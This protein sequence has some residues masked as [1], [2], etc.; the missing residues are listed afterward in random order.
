MGT[1]TR[2]SG[3]R[4]SEQSQKLGV[5]FSHLYSSLFIFRKTLLMSRPKFSVE[6]KKIRE[7]HVQI[8][9]LRLSWRYWRSRIILL[10][11]S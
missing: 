1:V 6:H 7:L 3:R 9:G 2:L 11:I 5:D 4:H 8:K 10:G